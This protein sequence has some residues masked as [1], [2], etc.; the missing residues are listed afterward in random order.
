MVFELAAVTAA[1]L[2]WMQAVSKVD[3]WA[4]W[5]VVGS[6]GEMVESLVFSKVER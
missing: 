2:G 4:D 3:L 5:K 6:V 1:S